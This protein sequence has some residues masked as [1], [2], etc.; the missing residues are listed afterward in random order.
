MIGAGVYLWG[1]R[2]GTVAQESSAQ[3]AVFTYEKDFLRSG[4][5]LSPLWM[6]LS[7]RN[8]SFPGLRRESFRG[9]PGMLADSLPD[10]Y[11]TRLLERAFAERGREAES[12]LAVERLCYTGSRGM[13]ALEYRPED[14]LVTT[15]DE[16]LDLDVLVRAASEVLTA[17]EQLRASSSDIR[18]L[19]SVGTSAGG[20]R[21][22]AVIAWNRE[23]GD[24]RSGQIAA[25]PGY[26]HWIVKFDGVSG[27]RDHGDR[28]DGTEFTR[29]EYAYHRMAVAA[30]ID[31]SE[32]LLLRQ[33][34]K[35]H[36][37]TKRFDRI[38][39]SGEKLHMQTLGAL[40]H[41]DFNDP[42]TNSYEQA[43]QVLYRLGMGKK[44]AEQLYRRMVFNVM[45]RNQDDHV[46]NISFLMDRRGRWSLAPAYDVTFAMDPDNP[47]L[48]RHQ[49][50]VNGKLENIS[51]EDLLASAKNMNLSELRAKRIL[52]EVSAALAGWSD[53]AEEAFVTEPTMEAVQKQFL[54]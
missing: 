50:S 10:R 41:Y 35:Y 48:R 18:Q 19:I 8:Y 12:I 49:M 36:F 52:N 15:I 44:E 25:R 13:G 14:S 24:I 23:T 37:A 6:P 42:G 3:A 43:A 5:E 45:A 28:D 31:M 51:A 27:N 11:G 54:L 32:C 30:G 1:T 7:E 26:E 22:K 53:F 16:S 9:L 40:A 33:A 17:R 38:G 39:D 47:W 34:G 20:A 29:I 46:K 21:A 4:I 2:I